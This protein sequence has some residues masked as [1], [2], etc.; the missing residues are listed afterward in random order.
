MARQQQRIPEPP[1]HLSERS[2]ELWRQVV[3]GE[4][5]TPVWL[6][7]L[8]TGLEALDR[9][10][11]CR[12]AVNEQGLTSTSPRS[13]A[14]HVHPLLKVELESRRQ[15]IQILNALGL[16]FVNHLL[17]LIGEEE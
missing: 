14:R 7:L 1:Y 9:A 3:P 8:T 11:E 13:G 5:R 15:A 6:T 17:E 12:R 10:D 4:P 2:K 16:K